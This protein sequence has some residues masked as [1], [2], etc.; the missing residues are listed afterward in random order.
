MLPHI[1]LENCR[2]QHHIRLIATTAAKEQNVEAKVKDIVTE[3]NRRQRRMNRKTNYREALQAYV[4]M[5]TDSDNPFPNFTSESMSWLH[6][7]EDERLGWEGGPAVWMLC[8][9]F[10]TTLG[11]LAHDILA[12]MAEDSGFDDL[13]DTIT[14]PDR[15]WGY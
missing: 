1:A 4:H 8:T 15:E 7:D 6:M 9:L 14:T 2:G 5:C 13:L 10:D 11:E 12:M 3:I